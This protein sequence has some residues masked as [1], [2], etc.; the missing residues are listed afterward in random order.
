VEHR[1]QR[2]PVIAPVLIILAAV[3]GAT[4]L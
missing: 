2:W 1:A 4:L 3:I